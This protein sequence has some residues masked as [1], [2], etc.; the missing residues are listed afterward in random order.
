LGTDD[1]ETHSTSRLPP[2]YQN[3]SVPSILYFTYKNNILETK[4][5][6]HFYSNVLKTITQYNESMKGE[7]QVRFLDDSDCRMILQR[8]APDLL[9]PFDQEERG[10]IKADLCRTAALTE[11]GGFYFDVDLE[12]I[13]PVTLG[14]DETF[15]SV[16][17]V[18][19]TGLFQAFLA[20]TQRHPVL[21]RT[22]ELFKDYY[23]GSYLVNNSA[24]EWLG[25]KATGSALRWYLTTNMTAGQPVMLQELPPDSVGKIARRNHLRYPRGFHGACNVG[26]ALD[27]RLYFWSR[28]RGSQHCE[29]DY[30]VDQ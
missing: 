26:C 20:A 19:N 4:E 11:T 10:M 30:I 7:A 22:L 6:K 13:E 29:P 28:I 3:S 12:V 8:V 5:P 9:E 25:T 14:P 24:G 16:Y 23:D 2:A 17:E 1:T 27:K 15:S 21:E 18:W